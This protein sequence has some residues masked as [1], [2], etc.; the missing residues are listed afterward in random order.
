MVLGQL[1]SITKVLKDQNDLKTYH[2]LIQTQLKNSFI[3]RINHTPV[4]EDCH[5]LPH[6][7]VKK[8]SLTALMRM[9]FDCSAKQGKNPSLNNCLMTGPSMAEKLWNILLR[10]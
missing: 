7:A 1:R 3:E 6:H 10:F 2:D 9:V 8:D 5:R 4:I